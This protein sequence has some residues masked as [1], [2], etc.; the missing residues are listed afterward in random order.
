MVLK[1]V[2]KAVAAA[3]PENLPEMHIL[4]PQPALDLGL[5]PAVCELVILTQADV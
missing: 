1:V 2:P 5:E 3:S 4:R